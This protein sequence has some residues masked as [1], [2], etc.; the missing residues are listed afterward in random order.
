MARPSPWT[1]RDLLR[2][3]L[4]LGAGA[5]MLGLPGVT[6]AVGSSDLRFIF[7]FARGGWD[8]SRV[9]SPVLG[10]PHVE[11]EP[12]AAIALSLLLVLL[13]GTV[14]FTLRRQWFPVR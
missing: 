3:G 10:S 9:F 6:R 8:T 13:S 1:R 5:A 2:A 11:T 14:L 4:G 7:V 12:D